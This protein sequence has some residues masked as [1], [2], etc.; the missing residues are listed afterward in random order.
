MVAFWGNIVPFFAAAFYLA[1]GWFDWYTARVLEYWNLTVSVIYTGIGVLNFLG[2]I[3]SPTWVLV[4]LLSTGG[5]A[6][7]LWAMTKRAPG[8]LSYI[9]PEWEGNV[10][11]GHLYPVWICKE[12]EGCDE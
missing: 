3:Y 2:F 4:N 5:N 9:D 11:E 12:E 6:Y 1:F 10:H 7:L 8:A